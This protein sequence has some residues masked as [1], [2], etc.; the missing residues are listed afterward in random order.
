MFVSNALPLQ[1]VQQV[2]TY[3]HDGAYL[4]ASETESVSLEMV[5]YSPE[6]SV[7]GYWRL[8]MTWDDAGHVVGKAVID[9][10]PAVAYQVGGWVGG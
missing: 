3:L 5:T 9:G 2:L 4:S 6:L 1:R 8:D 10:L 7:F